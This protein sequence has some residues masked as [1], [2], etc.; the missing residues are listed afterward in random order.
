MEGVKADRELTK[1]AR[2][3]DKRSYI[4]SDQR[5][6]LFGEDWKQRKYELLK[7]SLGQCERFTVLGRV[8]DAWCRGEGGEPHHIKR[9][10][11]SRDDR[12]DNLANLSHWCHSAEDL[13][14]P[15]WTKRS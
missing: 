5:E 10:S 9:R 14:K 15:Q 1:L 4:A 2:F 3:K 6:I 11:V 8:H 7:R 13:R 12:L